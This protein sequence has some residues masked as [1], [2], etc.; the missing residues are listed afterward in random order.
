[1]NKRRWIALIALLVIAI[2]ASALCGHFSTARE[3]RYQ[4]RLLRNWLK[5]LRPPAPILQ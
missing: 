1:V 4:G 2:V 3:S 5:D